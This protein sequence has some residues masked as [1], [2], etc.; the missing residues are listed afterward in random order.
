LREQVERAVDVDDV[1][2]AAAELGDGIQQAAKLQ[3]PDER[4]VSGSVCAEH[5]GLHAHRAQENCLV[6]RRLVGR[7]QAI[8][9][10]QEG[11]AQDVRGRQVGVHGL[12][13][14]CRAHRAGVGGG[15]HE[16]ISVECLVGARVAKGRWRRSKMALETTT[17]RTDG[18]RPE[19]SAISDLVHLHPPKVPDVLVRTCAG[20][21]ADVHERPLTTSGGCPFSPI[22]WG[23]FGVWNILFAKNAGTTVAGHVAVSDAIGRATRCSSERALNAAAKH[24]PNE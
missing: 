17:A 4:A 20:G 23:S 18:L 19:S 6:L 11:F 7:D 16:R 5:E 21:E 12:F 9:R 2:Q 15:S 14:R 1:A 24:P 22:S 10:R 3:C 13:G 8:G